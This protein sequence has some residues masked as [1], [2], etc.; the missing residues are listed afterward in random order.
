MV[1]IQR[2]LYSFC[3][4]VLNRMSAVVFQCKLVSQPCNLIYANTLNY[5]VGL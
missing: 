5:D 4:L 2:Y 1:S 3:R